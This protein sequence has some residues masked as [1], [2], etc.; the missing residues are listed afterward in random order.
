MPRGQDRLFQLRHGEEK[1]KGKLKVQ[2]QLHSLICLKPGILEELRD[3]KSYGQF[4]GLTFDS[5]TI[6]AKGRRGSSKEF[7][8]L[9]IFLFFPTRYDGTCFLDTPAS[10]FPAPSM[11][12]KNNEKGMIQQETK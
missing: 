8:I 12:V 7:F 1:Y 4:F 3:S 6:G 2:K 5:Q 11:A 9:L 10:S